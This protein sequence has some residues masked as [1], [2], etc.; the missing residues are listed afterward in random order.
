VGLLRQSAPS[1]ELVVRRDDL[2]DFVADLKRISGLTTL[3]VLLPTWEREERLEVVKHIGIERFQELVF[4]L[5][6]PLVGALKE[7]LVKGVTFAQLAE[8]MGQ[9]GG[10]VDQAFDVGNRWKVPLADVLG[11]VIQVFA[12]DLD[13]L[14]PVIEKASPSDREKASKDTLLLAKA[15]SKLSV[16]TYLGLLPALGVYEGPSSGKLAEGDPGSTHKKGAEADQ[17][18]RYHLQKYVADAVRA[19]RKVEGE[20][21][22]VGDTDFQMAFDR[23]WVDT[24]LFAKNTVA[25]K[26][27]NAFVDVNLSKR[28][29]WVHRDLGNAGTVIHEGMHKYADPTLRN[30]QMSLVTTHGGISQLDEGITEL[31]TRKVTS[32]LKI[33]RGNYANPFEMADLLEKLVGDAVVAKAYFDGNFD[34]LKMAYEKARPSKKWNVVALALEQ[35]DWPVAKGCLK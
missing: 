28:H 8:L 32:V 7:D 19:G 25:K 1:P 35:K 17:L 20:V 11:G 13:K 12:V 6:A 4:A 22:V 34:A 14:K 33:A 31:F 29:I 30:E 21:S 9:K 15:K 5:G 26:T 18:I 2:D 23:Q 24:G 27:C 16:D 10:T 3:S